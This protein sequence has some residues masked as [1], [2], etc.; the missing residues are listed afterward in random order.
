MPDPSDDV[1]PQN[2]MSVM[3]VR[4]IDSYPQ[5]VKVEDVGH[6]EFFHTR[7]HNAA[8]SQEGM[9][10]NFSPVLHL[11]ELKHEWQNV[12][13]DRAVPSSIAHLPKQTFLNAAALGIQPVQF[14]PKSAHASVVGATCSPASAM[15]F[16]LN[17]LGVS[18]WNLH[19]QYQ[20]QQQQLLYTQQQLHFSQ[21]LTNLLLSQ[22]TSP[23]PCSFPPFG[24]IAA[25][26]GRF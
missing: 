16:N 12:S 11:D 2:S 9:H 20:Q 21:T 1:S 4:S 15:P 26:A 13:N 25:G 14:L 5:S 17:L 3:H 24:T 6:S 23:P 7:Y 8:K 19:Q 18:S 10:S 22:H